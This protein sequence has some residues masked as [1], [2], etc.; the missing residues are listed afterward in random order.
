M[1]TRTVRPLREFCQFKSGGTPS[2]TEPAYWSGT[3]PWVSP[4]D[5]TG[6]VISDSVDHLSD[7]GVRAARI[8]VA[9]IDSILVVVRSGI[10]AHTFPVA[11]LAVAAAY[12]QDIK[13]IH[14]DQDVAIPQFVLRF[15]QACKV[16]VLSRGV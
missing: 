7:V 8:T 16:H 15:L 1:T 2:R 6:D 9:P 14:V 4:K 11:R 10:L 3:I 13:S 5:M 12:N